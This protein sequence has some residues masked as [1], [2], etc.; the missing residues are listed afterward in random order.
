MYLPSYN[1]PPSD[2]GS[3]G[4]GL[5]GHSAAAA[6]VRSA[7]SGYRGL[8]FQEPRTHEHPPPERW[9][10]HQAGRPRITPPHFYHTF[11]ETCTAAD[12]SQGCFLFGGT[13][14]KNL[15]PRQGGIE[16]SRSTVLDVGGGG[17]AESSPDGNEVRPGCESPQA[18][19]KVEVDPLDCEAGFGQGPTAARRSK[20]RCPYSKQQIRELEKE[21]L[22]NVYVNKQRRAQLSRLLHLTDRQVK[23]WF[24]NRRMKEKKL[25]RMQFYCSGLQPLMDV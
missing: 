23:I 18:G 1:H 4:A 7:G 17:A 20:K 6:A 3:I 15:L 22:F 13:Q 9:A 2:S 21:F 19:R 8:C 11:Q 14:E 12:P 25:G 10:L 24:Q 5:W 16:E